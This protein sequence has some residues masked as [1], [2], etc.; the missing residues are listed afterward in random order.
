MPGYITKQF[1]KYHHEISK[2]PQHVPYPSAPKKYGVAAQE[3]IKID[4]SNSAVPEG[5]NRVQ[6]TVVII[7]Y[8]VRCV[9]TTIL[10]AISTLASEKSKPTALTIKN[11][12]QLLYYI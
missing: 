4:Y 7:L 9:G 3:P 2:L 6:K 5:I 12:H 10:M 1:Q 8:Y 11:L